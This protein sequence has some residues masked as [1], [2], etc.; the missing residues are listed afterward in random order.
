[1]SDKTSKM[2]RPRKEIDWEAFDKLALIQCTMREVAAWFDV[3]EDTIDRRVHETHGVTFAEYMAQ[4]SCKGKIS[5]RRKQY[6][7]AMSGNTSLL[8]WLGKQWLGQS[9]KMETR[10]EITGGKLVIDLGDLPKDE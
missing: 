9:D 10:S 7:A 2:G 6:Q 5:L 1:M 4:R 8:I 3:S